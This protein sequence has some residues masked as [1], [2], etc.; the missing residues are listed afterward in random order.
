ME[1]AVQDALIT[2]LKLRFEKNMGRH[3]GI[4]WNAVLA[5]LLKNPKKLAALQEMERTGG[6]PDVIGHDDKTQEFLFCDCSPESPA[7]R[8]SLCYDPTALEARKENK[9][10]GSAIG[11]ASSMGLELLT[12]EQYRML[13][14]LGDF[15]KKTSSWIRTPAKIRELGGYSSA[16][17]A[18]TKHS[19]T[20]MARSRTMALGAFEGCLGFRPARTPCLQS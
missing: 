7:G 10:S 6:E 19:C 20:T 12:E 11:M 9:P 16:I 4:D 8:R 14:K 2:T 1:A 5:K 18:T 3:P 13:Q 17:A 15:D